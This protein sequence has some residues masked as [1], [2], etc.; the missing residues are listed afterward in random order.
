M[1][2]KR[3]GFPSLFKATEEYDWDL[4]NTGYDYSSNLMERVLSSYMFKNPIIK[5]FLNMHIKP[6][7]IKYIDGV[8]YLRIFYNFAVPKDYDKIN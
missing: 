1:K 8:K 2:D 6:I 4:K 5:E 7:I 3:T